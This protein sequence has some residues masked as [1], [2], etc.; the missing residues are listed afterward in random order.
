MVKSWCPA[1]DPTG[2]N[3]ASIAVKTTE[4][5]KAAGVICSIIPAATLLDG[6]DGLR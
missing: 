2:K 3:G 1:R 5:S 6:P 4:A